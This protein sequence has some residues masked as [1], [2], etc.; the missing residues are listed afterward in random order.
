MAVAIARGILLLCALG[1]TV[2]FITGIENVFAAA[3]DGKIV[4]LWRWFGFIVFA[5]IFTLLALKPMQ[6]PGIWEIA[7]FHKLAMTVSALMLMQDNVAEALFVALIDGILALF[8]I[9]AYVLCKGYTAW[10]AFARS[11]R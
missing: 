8:V 10:K 6:Y 5:G 9:S 7:I 3:N 1:A 4:E 11:P 2:A